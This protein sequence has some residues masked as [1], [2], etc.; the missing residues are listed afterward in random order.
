MICTAINASISHN[1]FILIKEI[2]YTSG[3]FHILPL[4]FDLF[5]FSQIRELIKYLF[6]KK[7][8]RRRSV[9]LFYKLGSRC[10]RLVAA[11][12]NNYQ[13]YL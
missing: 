5:V 2:L 1:L 12:Q 10:N 7:G 8:L 13:N 3:F 11:L 4:V 9:L 6:K